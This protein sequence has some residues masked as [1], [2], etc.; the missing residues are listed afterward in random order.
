MDALSAFLFRQEE[1]L[2]IG[3]ED[4]VPANDFCQEVR[5]VFLGFSTEYQIND[6]PIHYIEVKSLSKSLRDIPV[7]DCSSDRKE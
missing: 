5:L 1:H 7:T 2:H 4:I 3:Q 6:V